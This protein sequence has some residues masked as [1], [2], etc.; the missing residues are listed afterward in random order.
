[1]ER[2]RTRWP[3]DDWPARTEAVKLNALLPL[4]RG[5]YDSTWTPTHRVWPVPADALFVRDEAQ[6]RRLRPRPLPPGVRTL[7]RDDDGA[8]EALWL[9]WLGDATGKPEPA[10]R[11]WA[12]ADFAA[13]LCEDEVKKAAAPPALP[14]RLEIHLALDVNTQTAAESMLFATPRTETLEGRP[15]SEWGLGVRAELPEDW[16]VN[17]VPLGADRRPACVSKLDASL[18]TPPARLVERWSAQPSLGLRLLVVTPADF[19]GWL[20]PRFTARDGEYRGTL[21][22]VTGECLLRAALVP[23]SVS[24]SGWDMAAGQPKPLRRLVPAGAVYFVVKASGDPVSWDEAEK[25]WLAQLGDGRDD[26]LGCV[27]PGRWTPEHGS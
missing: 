11:W 24:V 2:E 8:R 16:D 27:V 19:D 23:R 4:R 10:P 25:L 14:S 13:W 22:G 1:M 12:E 15:V 18:F 5:V 26:G 6:V 9:P 17:D 7:G 21:P 20:L 3:R